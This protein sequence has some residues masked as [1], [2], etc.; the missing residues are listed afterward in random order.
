MKWALIHR[1]FFQPGVPSRNNPLTPE[2]TFE[3]TEQIARFHA[4]AL[5]EVGSLYWTRETFDDFYIG[6]GSTYPD[7]NGSIGILYEQGSSRGHA[8]DSDYGL[9]TF[10]FTI[11]NQF[12]TTISTMRAGVALREDL[13]EHQREFFQIGIGR[14]R[15]IGREGLCIFRTSR[16]GQGLAFTRYFRSSSG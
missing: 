4:D 9:L 8:Q 2:R 14:S 12:I 3:L 16:S 13:L 10:P 11:R 5:D 15:Q 6:K 1:T 7:I